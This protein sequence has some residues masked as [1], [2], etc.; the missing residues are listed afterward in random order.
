VWQ[1]ATALDKVRS[2]TEHPNY[3]LLQLPTTVAQNCRW[4][5]WDE[6]SAAITKAGGPDFDARTLRQQAKRLRLVPSLSE[7]KDYLGTV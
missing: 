5:T 2:N 7:V 4:Q 3:W 6:V 1:L